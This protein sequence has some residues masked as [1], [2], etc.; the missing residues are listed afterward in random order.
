MSVSLPEALEQV[1]LEAGRTYQCQVKGRLV[2]VRV[3]D[4]RTAEMLPAAP[5]E[6]DAMLDPWVELPIPTGELPL[7]SRP[8]PLPPPDV[9]EIP[10]DEESP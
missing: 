7:R 1:D 10:T 4:A 2:L 8:G 6:N 9:P 3:L 5:T